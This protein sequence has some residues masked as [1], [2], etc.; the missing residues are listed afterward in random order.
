MNLGRDAFTITYDA[1]MVDVDA[2]M[3]RIRENSREIPS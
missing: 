1:D 3:R 2:I